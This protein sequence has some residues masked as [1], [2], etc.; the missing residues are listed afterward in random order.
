MP[1]QFYLLC[2]LSWSKSWNYS[3]P[4]KMVPGPI[5][6]IIDTSSYL[7]VIIYDQYVLWMDEQQ[8]WRFLISKYLHNPIHC[9]V[10][11]GVRVGT[12]VNQI[13]WFLVHYTAL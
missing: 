7:T 12:I 5:H 9:A 10:R 11:V 2:R 4:N 1:A 13:G 8:K 6:G 3:H